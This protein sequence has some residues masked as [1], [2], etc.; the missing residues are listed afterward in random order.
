M[1]TNLQHLPPGDRA[2]LWKPKHL[3]GVSLF[4]ARFNKFTYKK[5]C[6]REY[7]IGVI[8]Y[9]AQK[10]SHL[11]STYTASPNTIIT[12]N[13]GEVHDG[14]SG[15]NAG[16]QY[17]MMYLDPS[18]LS[19]IITNRSDSK[20]LNGHF[21][22]PTVCDNQIAS[23]LRHALLLLDRDR[24][25]RLESHTRLVWTISNLFHRYAD[26]APKYHG[27]HKDRRIVHLALEYIRERVS[28]NITLG[29][30]ATHAGLSQYHFLRIFKNTTGLPP[31]AYLVQMRIDLAKDIIE[32]GASLAESAVKSGFSDQSHM[33]RW[34]KAVHGLT[35]GQYQKAFF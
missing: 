21:K 13:P 29:E 23:S 2:L 33:T 6:H 20:A 5:H 22:K 34:F 25:N 19:K 17:R 1:K 32:K 15:S 3:D 18:K 35:P 11:G 28:D 14:T 10:F 9:G 24:H 8:E 16:Y 12:V 7:A 31:H 30:I 27:R 26:L 4:K